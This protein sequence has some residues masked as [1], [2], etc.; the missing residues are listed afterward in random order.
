[1]ELSKTRFQFGG[2][3]RHHFFSILVKN[4]SILALKIHRVSADKA[5]KVDF[6]RIKKQNSFNICTLY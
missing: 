5:E 4:N 2:S 6:I 1:M 3:L